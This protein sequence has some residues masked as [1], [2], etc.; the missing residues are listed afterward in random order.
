MQIIRAHGFHVDA[1]ETVEKRLWQSLS[2]ASLLHR[3]LRSEHAEGRWT[4]EG[5]PE[6]GHENLGSVVQHGVET[7]EHWLRREI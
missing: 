6:L 5:L 7:F 4:S 3:I 2:S 1:R